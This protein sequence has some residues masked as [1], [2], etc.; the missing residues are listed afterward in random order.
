MRTADMTSVGGGRFDSGSTNTGWGT[1]S[2]GT[3]GVAPMPGWY[4]SSIAGPSVMM[5]DGL[6]SRLAELP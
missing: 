3:A 6:Q 2:T 5:M 4:G 1:G